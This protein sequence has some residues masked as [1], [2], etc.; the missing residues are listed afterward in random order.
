MKIKIFIN[1]LLYKTVDLGAVSNY[2]PKQFTDM[3]LADKAA[4]KIDPSFNI[5]QGL[6]I[7]LVKA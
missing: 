7:S 4:G 6:A 5:D 2:E 3:V 1:T